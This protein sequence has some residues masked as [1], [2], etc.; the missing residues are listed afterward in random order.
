MKPYDQPYANTI[1]IVKVVMDEPGQ[2]ALGR[3]YKCLPC[4]IDPYPKEEGG[5]FTITVAPLDRAIFCASLNNNYLLDG[6]YYIAYQLKPG[7]YVINNQAVFLE[8]T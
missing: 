7:Y 3:I 1:R 8:L 2:F 6:H 4:E 5:A